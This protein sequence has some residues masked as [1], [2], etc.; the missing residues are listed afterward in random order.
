MPPAPV[1]SVQFP[2]AVAT[3]N[4]PHCRRVA[5]LGSTGSIGVSTLEVAAALPDRGQIVGLCTHSNWQKLFEQTR[6]FKPRW[7]V[8][9][10]PKAFAMADRAEFWPETKLLSG[11]DG[12]AH[13]V[14]RSGRGHRGFGDCRSGGAARNLGKTLG[15]PGNP[16]LWPTGNQLVISG[17][18]IM[19]FAPRARQ[20][21]ATRG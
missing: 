2:D 4:L 18:L 15:C 8:L 9:T 20:W 10:D 21:S 6:L 1:D 3:Q 13:M 19:K 7:A 14:P 16:S 11:E 5:V 17:E 12:I